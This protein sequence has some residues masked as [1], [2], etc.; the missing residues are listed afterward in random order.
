V[1]LA[2]S[3]AANS[4]N[5]KN[6]RS[7]AYNRPMVTTVKRPPI[8]PSARRAPA[9]QQVKAALSR[10]PT[11]DKVTFQRMSDSNKSAVKKTKGTIKD[12]FRW[13]VAKLEAERS[14]G[15]DVD[16]MTPKRRG[17]PKGRGAPLKTFLDDVK[18]DSRTA[19]RWRREG[20]ISTKDFNDFTRSHRETPD[21]ITTNEFL[22]AKEPLRDRYLQERRS[23]DRPR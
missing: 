6:F 3:P 1:K 8:Q 17:G 7:A 15:R 4:S 23:A 9:G 16:K 12:H 13:A 20:R 5:L 18:L 14:I 21:K 10:M 19:G 22:K 2:G 11:N